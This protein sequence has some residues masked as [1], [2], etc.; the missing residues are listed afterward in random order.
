MPRRGSRGDRRPPRSRGCRS[1]R[2]SS[3]PSTCPSAPT[4]SRP[5]RSS[6]APR[7]GPAASCCR[8]RTSRS[9][10]S[11]CHGR[12]ASTRRSSRASSARRSSS[13]SRMAPASSSS[14]PGHGP[15]DLNHLIKRVCAEMEA[16]QDERERRPRLRPLLPRAERGARRRARH[17][18]AGRGRPRLDHRDVVGDGD[19]ARP[20]RPRAAARGPGGHRPARDLRPEPARSREPRPRGA[21]ARLHAPRSSPS[22]P[23]ASSPVS[24]ST[25]WPTCARSSSATGRSRCRST[26]VPALR[27]TRRSCCA[28]RDRCRATSPRSTSAA[29]RPRGRFPRGRA[30][31]RHARRDRARCSRLRRSDRRAGFYVRRSQSADVRLPLAVDVGPPH[32]GA[33]ARPRGRLVDGARHRGRLR[34][35]RSPVP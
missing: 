19:G 29:R 22:V 14:T 25:R 35:T 9:A 24:G 12:S 2:S 30:R 1:A 32:R 31:Q 27:A 7:D 18:L 15:L 17:R 8:G 28:T 5:S 33:G 6:S 13:S 11:R 23:L 26:G 34:M 10:R 4:A 20:C 21:A 3:T 16:A